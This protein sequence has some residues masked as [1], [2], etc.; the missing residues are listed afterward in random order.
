[1]NS[2]TRV[3]MS[4]VLAAL[5]VSVATPALPQ[6]LLGVPPGA[7]LSGTW[8][9]K[10]TFQGVFKIKYL[11][12][13]TRDGRTTLLLPFGGPVNADDTRV[14]CMGEWRPVR[15]HGVP[16]FDMTV[17]CLYSQEWDY[18]YGYGLIK[19]RLLLTPDGKGF[20]GDFSYWDHDEAG[21]PLWGGSGVMEAERLEIMPLE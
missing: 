8:T 5:L 21:N 14:G 15:P 6:P 7:G 16:A 12:G 2:L 9:V 18:E 20:T 11:Q 17:K 19:A 10:V 4:V 3:L 1:M 13:F